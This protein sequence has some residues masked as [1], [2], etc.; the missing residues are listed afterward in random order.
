MAGIAQA[1][2][3]RVIIY[4]GE[5]VN[6]HCLSATQRRLKEQIDDRFYQVELFSQAPTAL[7]NASNPVRLFVNPGGNFRE[8]APDLAFLTKKIH[9][10]VTEEESGYLGICAGAI[11]A[12]DQPILH[13]PQALVRHQV[14]SMQEMETY[15]GVKGNGLGLYAGGCCYFLTNICQF[16]TTM[17]VTSSMSSA[18]STYPLFF[19][20]GIFFPDAFSQPETRILLKYA[21]YRFSGMYRSK[22]GKTKVYEDIELAAA[23]TV[24]AGKGR[25]LLSGVHPEIDAE[26]A[27]QFPAE[28]PN[29]LVK[30][31]ARSELVSSLTTHQKEVTET[32]QNFLEVLS[33]ATKKA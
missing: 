1:T 7:D 23:I 8:M 9:R 33:I 11:A 26:A 4:D 27:K 29:L 28:P 30:E 12:P 22:L 16:Y 2:T 21:D 13:Y 20:S 6:P 18:S 24:P 19:E 14:S 10:C 17:D 31:K 3:G 5:G 32:M 15:E 25:L